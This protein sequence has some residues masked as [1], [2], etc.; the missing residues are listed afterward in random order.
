MTNK[1]VAF[2]FLLLRQHFIFR[3]GVIGPGGA[4][5]WCFNGVQHVIIF[6]MVI[7]GNV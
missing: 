6:S 3:Q 2:K 5:I 4:N 7:S 1:N